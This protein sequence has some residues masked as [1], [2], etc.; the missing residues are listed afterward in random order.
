SR[1]LRAT[2]CSATRRASGSLPWARRDSARAERVSAPASSCAT[3]TNIRSV[4]VAHLAA[5][6]GEKLALGGGEAGQAVRRDLLEHAIHLRL[7][8]V[9]AA[10][11]ALAATC[12]PAG[13]PDTRHGV[14]EDARCGGGRRARTPRQP[15]HHAPPAQA[16]PPTPPR[17]SR[18]RSS[19]AR[20]SS[21][22][23]APRPAARIRTA[24]GG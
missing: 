15:T 20:S 14:H 7:R 18:R 16:P 6:L 5:H 19:R 22:R 4:P 1:G 9:A 11:R 3:S 24:P 12:R 10:P 23:G 8:A 21:R 13:P 17:R 2:S